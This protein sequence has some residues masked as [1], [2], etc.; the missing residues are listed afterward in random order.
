MNARMLD[1]L[2]WAQYKNG[3][4]AQ[5]AISVGEALRKAP[6][7][8]LFLYHAAIIAYA[9]GNTEQ[10]REYA[11]LSAE[12]LTAPGAGGPISENPLS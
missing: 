4:H 11:G 10:A 7:E 6:G 1:A 12:A 3:Q 2:G 5:A 9:L 8:P